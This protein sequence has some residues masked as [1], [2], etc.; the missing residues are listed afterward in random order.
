[1]YI[2]AFCRRLLVRTNGVF[3]DL[4]KY[5]KLIDFQISNMTGKAP[6]KVAPRKKFKCSTPQCMNTDMLSGVQTHLVERSDCVNMFVEQYG[7][8][9]LK[10]V[11]FRADPVLYKDNLPDKLK[12]FANIGSL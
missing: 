2:L 8:M 3:C 6:I 4:K 1:M 5:S 10:A 9:P 7:Y 11:E 12:K